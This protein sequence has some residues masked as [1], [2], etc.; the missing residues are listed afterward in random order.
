MSTSFSR[1]LDPHYATF[2]EDKI[3]G[4]SGNPAFLLVRIGGIV[5]LIALTFWTFGGAGSG[6]SIRQY[7]TAINAAMT[8]NGSPYQL[9]PA[10]LSGNFTNYA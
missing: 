10:P 1:P 8:A 2:Y 5:R 4:D 6:T 9:T 3:G 7:L